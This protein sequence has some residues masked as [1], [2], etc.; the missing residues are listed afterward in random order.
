MKFTD[1]RYLYLENTKK[2]KIYQINFYAYQLG[3]EDD[4]SLILI[5]NN[6]NSMD[7]EFDNETI[8]MFN[9]TNYFFP[10]KERNSMIKFL[11]NRLIEYPYPTDYWELIFV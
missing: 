8:T 3:G 2:E 11:K 4:I 10:I 6:D 7:L 1:K 9:D 5:I